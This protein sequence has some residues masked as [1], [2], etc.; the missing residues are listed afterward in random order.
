MINLWKTSQLDHV[1]F[2]FKPYVQL[3]MLI[4]RPDSSTKHI[5]NYF[6]VIH[7]VSWSYCMSTMFCKK[8]SCFKKM[9]TKERF[10][11]MLIWKDVYFET[12]KIMRFLYDWQR[13]VINF[14]DTPSN[15]KVQHI[16]VKGHLLVWLLA[17]QW[18]FYWRDATYW[19]M[20]KKIW[21]NSLI[22]YKIIHG[23]MQ[24]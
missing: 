6:Y 10:I 18:L 8:K 19:L 12:S 15:C 14:H 16:C 1:Q 5:V 13:N 17:I 24:I 3:F 21:L 2:V 7:V 22:L 20:I 9:I 11:I 23:E 4:S